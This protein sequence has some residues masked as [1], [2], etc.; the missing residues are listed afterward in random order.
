MKKHESRGVEEFSRKMECCHLYSISKSI[1]FWRH[2]SIG[3]IFLKDTCYCTN[4]LLS[5]KT[6]SRSLAERHRS[7]LALV[8]ALDSSDRLWN[9]SEHSSIDCRHQEEFQRSSQAWQPLGLTRNCARTLL[10]RWLLGLEHSLV[11][12]SSWLLRGPPHPDMWCLT[13]RIAPDCI[14]K[15]S[16]RWVASLP[17]QYPNR[18]DVKERGSR[19]QDPNNLSIPTTLAR[20]T[21]LIASHRPSWTIN[22]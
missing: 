10:I 8:G 13:Y 3:I 4:Y 5:P 2:V 14:A 20:T 12:R 15:D 9:H 17:R 6:S 11:D 21:S 18:K 1:F 22:I 19:R 7:S 16:H